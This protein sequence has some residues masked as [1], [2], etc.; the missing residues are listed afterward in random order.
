MCVIIVAKYL[1]TDTLC[2]RFGIKF[3]NYSKNIN[4]QKLPR[5]SSFLFKYDHSSFIHSVCDCDRLCVCVYS[6]EIIQK[7]KKKLTN[8]SCQRLRLADNNNWP[9]GLKYW[10]KNAIIFFLGILENRNFISLDWLME[11]NV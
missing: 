11:E 9:N 8:F 4:P 3:K 7:L 1:P 6:T 10:Q 5:I 2:F